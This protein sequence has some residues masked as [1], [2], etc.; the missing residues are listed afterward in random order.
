MNDLAKELE[1]PVE[2][3][4]ATQVIL[5]NDLEVHCF[6]DDRGFAFITCKLRNEAVSPLIEKVR[7]RHTMR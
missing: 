3:R 1:A 6:P 2:V 4:D 7:L 5:H